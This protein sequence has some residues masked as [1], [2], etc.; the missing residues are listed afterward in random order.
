MLAG[1][2][3]TVRIVIFAMNGYLSSKDSRLKDS[4]SIASVSNVNIVR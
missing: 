4:S 2:L 3:V 1:H